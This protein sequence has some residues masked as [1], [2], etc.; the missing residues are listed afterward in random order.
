MPTRSTF[1]QRRAFAL[2]FWLRVLAPGM[3]TLCSLPPV[4]P[5]AGCSRAGSGDEPSQVEALQAEAEPPPEPWSQEGFLRDM[6]R[7]A[8]E[9]DEADSDQTE[10]IW[11]AARDHETRFFEATGGVIEGWRGLVR[12]HSVHKGRRVSFAVDLRPRTIP[13]DDRSFFYTVRA[14]VGLDTPEMSELALRLDDGHCVRVSGRIDPRERSL[15]Q[16]GALENPE[17]G[18]ALTALSPCSGGLP[19]SETPSLAVPVAVAG[20]VAAGLAAAGAELAGTTALAAIP[21]VTAGG[22]PVL[23]LGTVHIEGSALAAA[24]AGLSAAAVAALGF[25]AL[26]AAVDYL[27][28]KIE[29]R[30]ATQRA[31]Y[32]ADG[33]EYLAFARH[34]CGGQTMNSACFRNAFREAATFVASSEARLRAITAESESGLSEVQ[35]RWRRNFLAAKDEPSY[36]VPY[37]RRAS[38]ASRALALG[39]T[40]RARCRKRVDLVH[41]MR[42][43][44]KLADGPRTASPT[45]AEAVALGP[46]IDL[47]L[48]EADYLETEGLSLIWRDAWAEAG[49]AKDEEASNGWSDGQ[50]AA[51]CEAREEALGKDKVWGPSCELHVLN[52]TLQCVCVGSKDFDRVKALEKRASAAYDRLVRKR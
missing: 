13:D 6:A 37:A 22:T 33:A 4:L 45:M 31:A 38:E 11:Q 12:F 21:A 41:L 16:G 28:A 25:V 40:G 48:V 36:I 51:A 49:Y 5:L 15:T 1:S 19:P 42:E 43:E 2:P 26:G 50:H 39:E 17:H 14:E 24:G 47:L 20:S 35:L 8:E 34:V 27:D 18:I 3:W 44:Q 9:E 7:F 29:A 52:D 10:R 32:Q 46:C 30:K 23:I